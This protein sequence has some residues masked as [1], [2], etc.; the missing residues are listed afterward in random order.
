MSL[1][2]RKYKLVSEH[3]STINGAS[4]SQLTTTER[5]R[6]RERERDSLQLQRERERK[7]ERH[8]KHSNDEE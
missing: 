6:E 2:K 4:F 1:L 7:R 3:F 8:M 5:E